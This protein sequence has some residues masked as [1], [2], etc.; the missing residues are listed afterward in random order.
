MWI[1]GKI[2]FE[3]LLVVVVVR[4]V[5]ILNSFVFFVSFWCCCVVWLMICVK[6]LFFDFIG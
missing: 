2:V 1:F 4:I 5:G 6:G 3:K